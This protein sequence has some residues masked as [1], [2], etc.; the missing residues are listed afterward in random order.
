MGIDSAVVGWYLPY[1]RLLSREIS[2]CSWR[3]MVQGYVSYEAGLGDLVLR[4]GLAPLTFED[5]TATKGRYLAADLSSSLQSDA[6]RFARNSPASLLF[7]HLVGGHA[8]YFFSRT[9]PGVYQGGTNPSLYFDSVVLL[10]RS[11]GQFRKQLEADGR[12]DATSLILSTD[13]HMR[14]LVDG[15]MDPRIPFI[16]KLAGDSKPVTWDRQF[17]TVVTSDLVLSILR[18]DVRTHEQ[19]AAWLDSHGNHP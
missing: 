2:D 9:S 12:W 19:I 5:V 11:I 3:P 7:I 4:E 17:N 10:D 16:L 1:C 15:K 6:L 14:S 13:H 8:P 18:G